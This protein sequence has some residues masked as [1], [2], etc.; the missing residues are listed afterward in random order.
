MMKQKTTIEI[1]DSSSW[2]YLRLIEYISNGVYRVELASMTGE[3]LSTISRVSKIDAK[4]D[5]AQPV[6]NFDSEEFGKQMMRGLINIRP[7][8][9]AIATFHAANITPLERVQKK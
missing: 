1:I 6:I 5:D 8:C 2:K 4:N 3:I 7:I 9:H